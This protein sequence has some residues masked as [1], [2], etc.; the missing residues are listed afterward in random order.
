MNS[1]VEL[2]E[3]RSIKH[4]WKKF[5]GTLRDMHQFELNSAHSFQRIC[6]DHFINL[7]IQLLC[8]EFRHVYK[9]KF[10]FNKEL[11]FHV[12]FFYIN[13]TSKTTEIVQLDFFIAIS[14]D[15]SSGKKWCIFLSY[16]SFFHIHRI[17]SF[18]VLTNHF[19]FFFTDIA[20]LNFNWLSINFLKLMIFLLFLHADDKLKIRLHKIL[21]YTSLHSWNFQHG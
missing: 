1:A 3:E 16:S 6:W 12:I 14:N 17:S 4:N 19:S 11:S 9:L 21:D 13:L 10:G 18:V 5:W 7:L 20:L 2:A 15:E 8:T